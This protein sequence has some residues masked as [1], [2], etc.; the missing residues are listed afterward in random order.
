M[1]ANVNIYVMGR[2]AWSQ[3]LLHAP[4]LLTS[5]AHSNGGWGYCSLAY[6]INNRSLTHGGIHTGLFSAHAPQ[7]VVGWG[8]NCATRSMHTH[9]R[10]LQEASAGSG[11]GTHLCTQKLTHT[12]VYF[13]G[14]PGR[15][16]ACSA[17]CGRTA[18]TVRVPSSPLAYAACHG[19]QVCGCS[20]CD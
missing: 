11:I 12:H 3:C 15:C 4:G 20:A 7:Q 13:A 19:P 1:N 9:M 6:A 18:R 5:A 10:T 17:H 16:T 14:G 8:H 2:L